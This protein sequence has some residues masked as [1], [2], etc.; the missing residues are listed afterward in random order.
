MHFLCTFKSRL[1]EKLRGKGHGAKITE[2]S[3]T[4]G[5]KGPAK[6]HKEYK[7]DTTDNEMIKMMNELLL[8]LGQGNKQEHQEIVIPLL[9]LYVKVEPN[10]SWRFIHNL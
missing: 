3:K 10:I 5:R 1:V 6:K 7:I 8:I 9:I 2:P 4:P